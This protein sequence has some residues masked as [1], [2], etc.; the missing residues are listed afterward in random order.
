[1][2]LLAAAAAWAAGQA[3]PPD[4]DPMSFEDP[5]REAG[6]TTP[7][8]RELEIYEGRLIREI[9]MLRP[10][11]HDR[12]GEFVPLDAADRRDI[13]NTIRTRA[14]SEYVQRT[15]TG[16]IERLNRRG[17]YRQV[18]LRAALQTDG[19]IILYITVALQPIVRDVQSVG[20][21]ELSDQDIVKVV[22]I[23]IGTPVDRYQLDRACRRIKD[24]YRDKGFYL[25]ECTV[26][27]KA[28][29]E[30]EIV[31]FKVRE[32]E[33]VK[34]M[35]IRFEGNNSFTPRELRSQIK[36]KEAW[37]IFRRGPLDDNMLDTDVSALVDFYRDR[38]YLDVRVDRIVRT[39]PNG[40]EA[41]VTFVIDEGRVYTLRSLQVYFP[42]LARTFDTAEEAN[43]Q[44]APGETV[45]QLGAG[46]FAVFPPGQFSVEQL[47][48]MMLLKPG[49]VYSQDKMRKSFDAIREAYGKLG[50][51]F[52][53]PDRGAIPVLLTSR[54]L[55][56]PESPQVDM[57][58]RIVEGRQYK[59]GVVEII[60]NELT[61]HEVIRRHIEVEPD[62]PLDST[63]IQESR[64]RLDRLRLFQP[65]SVKITIQAPDPEDPEYRDVIA[66]ITETNTGSFTFGVSVGSDDGFG[67]RIALEQRNFDVTDW[68]DS[69]GEF[70]SGRAFRGAGQ[71]FKMEALPGTEVQLYTISLTEP[72][73]F[74][75]DYSASGTLFFRKRDYDEYDEERYGG[76]AS[77]GRRFGTR[78]VGSLPIRIESINLSDIDAGS[79]VDYWEV[80]DQNILTSVGLS[81]TRT[82][83]DDFIRPTK[84]TRIEMLAEQAGALGGD[85]TFTTLK[86]QHQ[87]FLTV[88]EGFLGDKTVLS[89][90]TSAGYI[91]QGPDEAPVY[92]RFYLGGQS[93]R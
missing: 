73:L 39:S 66:E 26:D 54:E 19:S 37:P 89:F 8:P 62:K 23:L 74:E 15:I 93:F 88:S 78:W 48:G 27:E 87:I 28:L 91:P 51:V 6:P 68:P 30:Q 22:S 58:L 67:G 61:R 63:A 1:M 86:A 79:P 55:R 5:P 14:G 71:T 4:E 35:D 81:L 2:A 47:R 76:R 31:L 92:E 17:R 7:P 42:R 36:T 43:R 11:G 9:T 3:D 12:P 64:K 18:D 69:F 20:N 90:K 65:G 21:K 82:S 59:T 24:L 56:D 70:A 80:A 34:V 52:D 84:G 72:Y 45:L 32:G 49:D 77:F 16:D 33:R 46:E 29:E 41:I 75:S 44:A 10:A 85:F 83:V 50:Y 53:D 57:L 60:G 40:R 25:A 13:E 38:G